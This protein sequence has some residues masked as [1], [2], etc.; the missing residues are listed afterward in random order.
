MNN[1][2]QLVVVYYR[3]IDVIFQKISC[4]VFQEI[5]GT[6]DGYTHTHFVM[7]GMV[8]NYDGKGCRLN[9]HVEHSVL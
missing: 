9:L 5:S 4:L 1:S 2:T 3:H 7:M 8:G 6:H